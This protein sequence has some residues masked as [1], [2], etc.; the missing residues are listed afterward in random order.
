VPVTVCGEMGGR[1]LEAL[2]LLALGVERLSITP[3]AVGPIK[4]MV[5]AVDLS[6]ARAEM[7]DWLAAPRADIRAELKAWAEARGV[8]VG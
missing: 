4:A 6:A 2:A 5:R 8:A 3:A 7:A 1:P